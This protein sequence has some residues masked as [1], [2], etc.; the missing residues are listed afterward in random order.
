MK[1]LKFAFLLA[2]VAI[3]ANGAAQLVKADNYPPCDTLCR[4]HKECGLGPCDCPATGVPIPKCGDYASG[5]WPGCPTDA[6]WCE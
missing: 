4:P 2:V 3:M 6:F 5:T 1:L